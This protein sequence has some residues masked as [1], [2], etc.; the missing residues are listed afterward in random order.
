M[1][2][3]KEAVHWQQSGWEQLFRF[4]SS[5]RLRWERP[6]SK[7]RD[8]G[9][10]EQLLANT[11]G[12]PGAPEL[13]PVLPTGRQA[14]AESRLP[15]VPGFGRAAAGMDEVALE[16]EAA[17]E[18]Q[19]SL[20]PKAFPPL[21]G[22]GLA[23]FC[24]SARQVGGDFYDVVSLGPDSALLVVADVMGKGVPA[25][26]FAG[27]LRTL[28]R[29][30]AESEARPGELLARIN[31]QLF[32]EL[33]AVDMFITAQLALVDPRR[34]RLAVASAGHCPLLM[35]DATCQT[36]TVAPEG[37][38][39]GILPDTEFA[40]EVLP[41]EPSSCALLYTDGLTDARNPQGESFEHERLAAWLGKNVGRDQ[42]A[43]QLAESCLAALAEFQ[44]HLCPEDDQT[45]VV[46]AGETS[47]QVKRSR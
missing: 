47:S 40:E 32:G 21:P 42:T 23:G 7:A 16:L 6:L 5:A 35:A 17:R 43:R 38:P 2:K 12:P 45:F 39:L 13:R 20:L 28:V 33:S 10:G 31:R 3:A 15:V 24:L 36:R 4:V 9:A 44:S 1:S 29:A 30:L 27:K 34:R 25:A 22:F 18:I 8:G 41:L 26:L 46:L 14:F 37:L 11:G 19:E